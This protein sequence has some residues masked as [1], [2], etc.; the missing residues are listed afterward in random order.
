MD[1]TLLVGGEAGQGIQTV[2]YLLAKAFARGGLYVFAD[3][4]YESR[5]RGGHNF[6]RVRIKDEPA[7]AI[8]ESVGMLLALNQETLDLHT[9]KVEEN[10][11]I[12]LDTEKIK[13]GSADERLLSVPLE[14]IARERC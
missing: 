13:I 8:S 1:F 9:A 10:G 2:G 4:D 11:V 14:R 3:Q 5:I 12:L 6:F 7:Y